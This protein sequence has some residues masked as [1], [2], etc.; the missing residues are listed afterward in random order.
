M[1]RAKDS[2]Q[3][4]V[5]NPCL[6]F[7]PEKEHVTLRNVAKGKRYRVV[8]ASDI[9]R[10]LFFFRTPRTLAESFK[11]GLPKKLVKLLIKDRMLIPEHE[12][13]DLWI[14]YNWSRASFLLFSQQN[15]PYQEVSNSFERNCD[16]AQLVEQRRAII[17]SYQRQLSYPQRYIPQSGGQELELPQPVS[18][19]A[20]IPHLDLLRNRVSERTFRATPVPLD[21][22]SAVLYHA[23]SNIRSAEQ[24]KA[25]GDPF[26]LLN[27]FYAWAVL[28]LYV[29][30]VE[31]VQPGIYFYDPIQH[32]LI[33]LDTG[34]KE[35][36]VAQVINSQQWFTGGG[37]CVFVGVQWE[38]YAW[39]YRHSRAYVNILIQLGELAQEFL[40]VATSFGLDGWIT[41]AVGETCAQR[42]FRIPPSAGVEIMTFL[43]FGFSVRRHARLRLVR[44]FEPK[45]DRRLFSNANLPVGLATSDFD[46]RWE[47][48]LIVTIGS[49]KALAVRS[50]EGGF[51]FLTVPQN[52][53][54]AGLRFV[55]VP[56]STKNELEQKY[57]INATLRRIEF[58]Y[59]RER[60]AQRLQSSKN[61]KRFVR[62]Y[63]CK[64]TTSYARAPTFAL[65]SRWRDSFRQRGKRV[66]SE[67]LFRALIHPR[68]RAKYGITIVYFEI[69]GRLVG[70]KVVYPY[71][72]SRRAPKLL[73]M[74]YK[75]LDHRYVG[76]DKFMDYTITQLFPQY[77]MIT[78]G[79]DF[80]G[81]E[82][83]D[84]FAFKLQQRKPDVQVPLYTVTVLGARE[85][86]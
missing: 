76:L 33:L 8:C 31:G 78:D 14:T 53:P 79:G 85:T 52:E 68:N 70:I 83:K 38:R 27:S 49:E 86:K 19:E 54:I 48:A 69:E 37:F 60:F 26:F 5:A 35:K 24:T 13:D 44:R 20:F 66:P 23:T 2:L 43:K 36:V 59:D 67:A 42:L 63:A 11:E 84:R 17:T 40:A 72:T 32:K 55:H 51:R 82:F 45:K 6:Y 12:C 28:F 30:G 57:H 29:Q 71:V 25:T 46:L 41:P 39:L 16:P 1:R 74:R 61:F 80:V 81:E 15:I 21:T 4:F 75:C 7:V 3:K 34:R 77:D 50:K 9:A 62:R 22:F 47:R 56:E 18:E 10:A 73:V 65:F 58:F 64:V